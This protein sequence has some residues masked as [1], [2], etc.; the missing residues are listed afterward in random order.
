MAADQ[1]ITTP[2][3]VTL[4]L[5]GTSVRPIVG[6]NIRVLGSGGGAT[7]TRPTTG[8]LYPRGEC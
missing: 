4:T 8:M 6:Q 1:T 2:T 5:V 7:N 3:I